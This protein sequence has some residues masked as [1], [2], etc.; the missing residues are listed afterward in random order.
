MGEHAPQLVYADS[1]TGHQLPTLPLLCLW[2]SKDADASGS[3][4]LL[5]DTQAAVNS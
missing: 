2:Y 1:Q 5:V 4:M 3:D